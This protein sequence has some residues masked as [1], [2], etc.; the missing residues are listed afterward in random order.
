MPDLAG[1]EKAIC[2][3]YMAVLGEEMKN[4]E[5]IVITA[6]VKAK[7]R[8]HLTGAYRTLKPAG[9]SPTRVPSFNASKEIITLTLT[10]NLL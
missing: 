10:L 5:E 2:L 7:N 6:E 9:L 4:G 1:E 3:L 8:G